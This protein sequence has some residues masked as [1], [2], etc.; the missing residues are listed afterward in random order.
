MKKIIIITML[1]LLGCAK[2]AKIDPTPEPTVNCHCGSTISQGGV[3]TIEGKQTEWWYQVRNY[4]TNAPIFIKV[5]R[6]ITSGEYCK[7]YQW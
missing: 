7:D 4:C 3:Y 1:A 2:E 6:P 5:I